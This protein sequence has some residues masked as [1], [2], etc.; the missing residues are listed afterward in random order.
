[1]YTVFVRIRIQAMVRCER[2]YFSSGKSNAGL[3]LPFLCHVHTDIRVISVTLK[4]EISFELLGP[5]PH[6]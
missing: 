1:M 6:R 3:S 2:E 4:L 5:K